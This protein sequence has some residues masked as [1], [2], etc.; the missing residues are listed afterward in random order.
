M[1]DDE[2]YEVEKI[3]KH[4][5]SKG[6][7]F[8]KLKWKGFPMSDC[9][10]EESSKLECPDLLAEY[11]DNIKSS[12]KTPESPTIKTLS[13]QAKKQVKPY[14]EK[15]S[16]I[17]FTRSEPNITTTP[18]KIDTSA[19]S[20]NLPKEKNEKEKNK[21][22]LLEKEKPEVKKKKTIQPQID[23][24][25]KSI[26]NNESQQK[27]ESEKKIEKKE[28]ISQ[29]YEVLAAARNSKTGSVLYLVKFTKKG[30]ISTKVVTSEYAK[31]NLLQPL[32]NFFLNNLKITTKPV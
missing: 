11:W 16:K 22:E 23:N 28:P 8:Y 18:K 5:I 2:E 26:K 3:L 32:I 6:V 12:K 25:F 29:E 9:T 20:L 13:P 4:K 27:P 15:Q 17:N 19:L 31:H 7:T 30:E 1:D 24:L 14:I 21:K 10:W